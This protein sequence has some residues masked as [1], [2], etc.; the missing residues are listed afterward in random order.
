MATPRQFTFSDLEFLCEVYAKIAD[1]YVTLSRRSSRTVI[2][3]ICSSSYYNFV[4][5]YRD[6]FEYLKGC[7]SRIIYG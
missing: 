1:C 5:S 3:S 2:L 4:F 6:C 7:I